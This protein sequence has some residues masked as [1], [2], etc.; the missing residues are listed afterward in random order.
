[1]DNNQ[2]ALAYLIGGLGV[3][4]IAAITQYVLGAALIGW[5]VEVVLTICALA[6]V[7]FAGA[8]Q[9]VERRMPGRLRMFLFVVGLIACGLFGWLFI[10]TLALFVIFIMAFVAS[11]LV[12]SL[13]SS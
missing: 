5:G 4:I 8:S 2:K 1:M 7:F 10:S 3:F 11:T 13:R 6:L 12:G 9:T